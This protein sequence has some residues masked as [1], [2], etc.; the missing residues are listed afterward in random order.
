[1]DRWFGQDERSTYTAESYMLSMRAPRQFPSFYS[2]A[3]V[4]STDNRAAA[5]NVAK[6]PV[7]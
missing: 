5:Y 3:R 7:K 6:V 2:T 4:M 1:M